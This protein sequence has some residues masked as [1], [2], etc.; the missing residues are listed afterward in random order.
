MDKIELT[1]EALLLRPYQ[2]KDAKAMA[3]AVNES[4]QELMPFMPWAHEGYSVKEAKTWLKKCQKG[5]K[6]GTDYQFAIFS[7]AD[8]AYLGGCGL[9]HINTLDRWCNLGYWVRTSR[10]KQGIATQAVALLSRF[11][12]EQLKFN[13]IEILAA[14]GNLASQRVAA[15]SGAVR[16][17]ILRNRLFLHEK[18]TDAVMFSLVPPRK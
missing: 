3:E 17:G 11:G 15:K 8:G 16:E 9:N 13:R 12:F 5:W 6:E 14:V 7:R 10:A 4:V 2:P 1:N 18:P